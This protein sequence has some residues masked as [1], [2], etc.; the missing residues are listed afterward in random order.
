MM[1]LARLAR[2]AAAGVLLLL[3]ALVAAPALAAPVAKAQHHGSIIGTLAAG[4]VVTVRVSVTHPT[5]WQKIQRVEIALRLRGRRL[6]QIVFRTAD[7]S[8]V[9]EG[10]GSPVVVGQAG[11]LQGPYFLVDASR[12]GLRAV[13]KGLTLSVPIR[14]QADPP[15]GGRLFYSFVGF[16][17]EPSGFTP[18]TPPVKAGSGFSWGTLGLAVAVAL[19]A[20]GFVGNLF[21]SNRRRA[22]PGPSVYAMVQSRLQQEREKK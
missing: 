6:D 10:D 16:G 21:A 15:P 13:G 19:F 9:V 12:V 22:Q 5:G 4:K 1:K 20:G 3:A 14:L 7:L 18:L 11:R 2:G 8:I 17:I